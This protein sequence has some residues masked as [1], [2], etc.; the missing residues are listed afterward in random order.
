MI[1]EK[2]QKVYNKAEFSQVFRLNLFPF[3]GYASDPECGRGV[4]RKLEEGRRRRRTQ[5]KKRG[6]GRRVGRIENWQPLAEKEHKKKEKKKKEGTG[7]TK[8][9]RKYVHE[10]LA[11]ESDELRSVR[12]E[13]E[14]GD[15]SWEGE[16]GGRE[17]YRAVQGGG[18]I[19]LTGLGRRK[20][21]K[22]EGRAGEYVQ[23]MRSGGSIK[24]R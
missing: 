9:S 1:Y 16:S 18:E 5:T 21:E 7:E 6:E 8:K 22:V 19:P 13:K 11:G 15:E 2:S 10:I 3:P 24:S 14:D 17:V 20:V 4:G 12:V 23:V